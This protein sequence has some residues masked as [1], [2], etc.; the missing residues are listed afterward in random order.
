MRVG[1][2]TMESAMLGITIRD[3]TP[4]NLTRQRTKVK[5]VVDHITRINHHEKTNVTKADHRQ[6]EAMRIAGKWIMTA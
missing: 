5:D 4:N 1:Q 6:A 2:R 3:R